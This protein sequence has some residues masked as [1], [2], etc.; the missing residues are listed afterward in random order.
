MSDLLAR[1][2]AIDEQIA[3]LQKQK[4]QALAD[5]RESAEFRKAVEDLRQ[6]YADAL[7]ALNVAMAV[8][9]RQTQLVGIGAQSLAYAVGTTGMYID[10]VE[11]NSSGR[12]I[13]VGIP[14]DWKGSDV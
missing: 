8:A 6:L 13:T 9:G 7:E 5:W 4:N 2:E 10:R 12:L 1:L 3:D 14:R 11:V